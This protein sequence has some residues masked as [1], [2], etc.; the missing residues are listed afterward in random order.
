MYPQKFPAITAL[1]AKFKTVKLKYSGGHV[2]AA[3]ATPET[4]NLK[5]P[6]QFK[7]LIRQIQ[8]PL[9]FP[10]IKYFPRGVSKCGIVVVV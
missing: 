10:F 6:S 8:Y 9:N 5:T 4:P 1:I 7:R 3:V 2:T